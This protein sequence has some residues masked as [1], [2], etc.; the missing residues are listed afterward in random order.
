MLTHMPDFAEIDRQ[1]QALGEVP[2][3]IPGLLARNLGQDRSRAALDQMLQALSGLAVWPAAPSAWPDAPI[4]TTT[5]MPTPVPVAPTPVFHDANFKAA[6]EIHPPPSADE[7]A[8][9]A[10]VL[11]ADAP[12]ETSDEDDFEML[13]EDEEILEIQED[14]V[15]EDVP[16]GDS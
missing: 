12:L 8:L 4:T 2:R 14:D 10:S 9:P 15:E 3:D 11:D 7:P 16:S 6:F 5:P 13:I 1:L